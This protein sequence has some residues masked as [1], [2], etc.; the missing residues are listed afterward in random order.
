MI[1]TFFVDTNLLVYFH[2]SG[3][4]QKQAAA[5]T[6]MARLWAERS[7]R[8]STQVLCEF[9]VT[10][11]QKLV[12]GLP[13]EQARRS[14]RALQAWRPGVVEAQTIRRAWSLQDRFSLSW[15]DALICSSAI[16][17]GCTCLLSEG[18]QQDQRIDSLRVLNPLMPG[19]QQA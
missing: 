9:Y 19:P 6:W 5:K 12:P 11:T 4:P 10:V 15:W 1:E 2:D 13:A 14:V 7:G 16:D 3:E 17:M 8:L 18:F